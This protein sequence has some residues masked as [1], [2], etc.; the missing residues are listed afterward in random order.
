LR[1]RAPAK[2]LVQGVQ[3]GIDFLLGLFA[4]VAVAL[5][6]EANEFLAPALDPIELVAG[7]LA[8][9]IESDIRRATSGSIGDMA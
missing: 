6:H 3:E 9:G 8:P 5:L 1:R 2:S 4:R 7:E